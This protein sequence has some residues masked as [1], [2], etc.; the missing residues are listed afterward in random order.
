M[1]LGRKEGEVKRVA[2]VLGLVGTLVMLPRG[3]AAVLVT[4]VY[5]PGITG[6]DSPPG[7][8]GAM[9]VK[10]VSVSAGA[11]SAIKRVDSASPQI[12]A[13]VAGATPLGTSRVLLYNTSPP[14]GAPDASISLLNTF[15]SSSV[16]LGGAPAT[17]QD[18]FIATTPAQLYLG[19]PGITGSSSTPGHANVMR[20]ESVSLDPGSAADFSVVKDVD[21]ASPQIAAAIAGGTIFLAAT[22]L[23]YDASPPGAQPDEIVVFHNV[24]GSAQL[25]AGGPT[26]REQ[27][28]FT[29]ATITPEPAAGMGVIS[30]AVAACLPRPRA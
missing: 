3:A 2:M 24:L 29:F 23:V 5:V 6:E 12:A 20:L 30:A 17:E 25:L 26:P 13:A 21:S 10:S 19:I 9:N 16:A 28:A 8:P 7:F 15:A 27:D 14:A 18:S 4:D 1:S 22:L 11:F